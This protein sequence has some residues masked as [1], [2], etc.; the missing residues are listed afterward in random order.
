ML[1]TSLKRE[2]MLELKLAF[3]EPAFIIPTLLF[4]FMFYVFFGLLFGQSNDQ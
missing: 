3:R 1:I 2:S 4:P